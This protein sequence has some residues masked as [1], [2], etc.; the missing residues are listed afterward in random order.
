[1]RCTREN[2]DGRK[3]MIIKVS[4]VNFLFFYRINC[5]KLFFRIPFSLI[6]I[7]YETSRAFLKKNAR[8]L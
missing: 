7:I 4:S 3:K 1:M 5:A 2:N 8:V 6:N